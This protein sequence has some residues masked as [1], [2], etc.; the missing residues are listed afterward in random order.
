MV[1]LLEE[2][3]DTVYLE[4]FNDIVAVIRKTKKQIG[5]TTKLTLGFFGA[6]TLTAVMSYFLHLQSRMPDIFVS[7]IILTL[8]EH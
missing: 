7:H 1:L 2:F 6:L 5:K 3:Y 8:H 4:P